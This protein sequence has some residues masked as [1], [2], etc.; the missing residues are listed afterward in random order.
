MNGSP[1]KKILSRLVAL[2][3]HPRDIMFC[4]ALSRLSRMQR[5]CTYSGASKGFEALSRFVT[6]DRDS[7]TTEFL[8]LGLGVLAR[9]R[10]LAAYPTNVHMS[11][12]DKKLKKINYS[13][14]VV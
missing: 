12:L 8:L 14:V 11:R 5:K 1:R 9:L 3:A 4:R 2:V 7:C 6:R 13:L 10:R